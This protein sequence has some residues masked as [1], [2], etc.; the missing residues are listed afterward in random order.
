MR[1]LWKER[2][3]KW[4]GSIGGN[5]LNLE[6]VVSFLLGYVELLVRG[7]HLEKFLNLLTNS[8][9]Y[10]WDVK[11][12]GTD[13]MQVKIRAH[14]FLRIR[15]LVRITHSTVKIYQKKGW[16]F[17]QRKLARRKIFWIG[18]ISVIGLLIYL[19][20]SVIFIRISGFEDA[21]RRQLL[22]NLARLGL[23]AG[24]SRREVM[25]RK[26]LIE[27]EVMIHTPGAVWLGIT[28]QGVVAEVKVVKRKSIP[29]ISNFCNIVAA[30]DGV[31]TKMVVIRGMPV[32]KEGDTVARGDLL[33]SGVEWLTNPEA[34]ELEKHE[35]AASGI[36]EAK[37]WYDLEA[38]EPKITWRPEV[39]RDFLRE[40]KFRWGRKVWHL[41]SFGRKPVKDYYWARWHRPLYQGRNPLDNVELI[42]DTWQAV[43][44]R[45]VVRT[46]QEIAQSALAEISQKRKELGIVAS[47]SIKTWSEEG[48][49]VKY[50]LT[51]EKIADIAMN[52]FLGKGQR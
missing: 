17:I 30:R 35:V 27:R 18:A 3:I 43:S 14:G 37:V 5:G 25:L 46:H 22:A 52:S 23:K 47:A 44:W 19:S 24:V 4:N 31:I 13:V 41:A 21:E 1:L 26:S 34:G 2:L 9:L 45:R 33:I 50:K 7:A 42:K 20:S 29:A 16:P 11:R 15:W 8:G 28:V 36:V 38:V 39:K 12:L 51:C 10:L 48:N 40:Y 32:V 6:L 49:F